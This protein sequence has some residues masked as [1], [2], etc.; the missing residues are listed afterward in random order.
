VIIHA[1]SDPRRSEEVDVRGTRRLIDAAR[2]AGVGH[3]VYISI[4]GVDVIPYPYYRRKLAAEG[5]I[6]RSGLP[7]STLRATQFHSLVDAFIRASA[8]M[9]LVMPLPTNFRFQS[10]ET[11]EV[12]ERLVNIAA[13]APQGRLP[14]FGGPEVLT[15]REAA[16]TWREIMRVSK[17][18][19]ALPLPGRLAA[20]F[21]AGKNTAPAGERGSLRWRDWLIRAMQRSTTSMERQQ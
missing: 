5:I 2:T 12:P 20:A 11:S 15:L 16:E 4:V 17:P 14:D 1:A 13:N 18:I 9:P 21:R 19:V 6:Q 10:V 8:R 3:V 7:W